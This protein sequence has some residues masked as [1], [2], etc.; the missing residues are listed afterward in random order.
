MAYN[1]H[2]FVIDSKDD[3][4]DLLEDVSNDMV[5]Y[6]KTSTHNFVLFYKH[7]THSD[8]PTFGKATKPNDHEKNYLYY[9]TKEEMLEIE[10]KIGK[11]FQ[12]AHQSNIGL[13]K[14]FYDKVKIPEP[15]NSKDIYSIC[16]KQSNVYL[17][18]DSLKYFNSEYT[19]RV[20]NI[21]KKMPKNTKKRNFNNLQLN[22]VDKFTSIDLH[23]AVHG[24]GTERDVE[25][26][27]LRHF[28]FK[29]DTFMFLCE[30]GSIKNFFILPE[31]N[32]SFFN[33]IGENNELYTNYLKQKQNKRLI[34]IQNKLNAETSRISQQQI[35]NKFENNNYIIDLREENT[36]KFQ[37][38]RRNRLAKE[39]MAFS[40]DP[41]QVF[42][43]FTFITINFDSLGALFVASHIKEFSE[44]NEEEKYDIN[45]GLLLCSNADALFDK[46]LITIDENKN[47]IFSFLLDNDEKLKHQLSLTKNIFDK[48]LNEQRMKYIKHH[49]DKFFELEEKRRTA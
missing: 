39:M 23:V 47:L 48:I 8:L 31:R 5:E 46:H 4:V 37:Q 7:L 12:T 30:L 18:N 14:D 25:F 20:F 29:G 17:V 21:L 19:E 22:L 42:C 11:P 34:E 27:V 2:S 6:I 41:E 9:L 16:D 38:K 40:A 3:I 15:R 32:P 26:H 13:S 24:I 45:N 28:M 44:C 36:R 35:E 10:Q 1:K 49:R 43:P 33:I